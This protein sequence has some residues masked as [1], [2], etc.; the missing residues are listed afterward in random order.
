[1]NGTSRGRSVTLTA[2]GQSG[3]GAVIDVDY[4]GLRHEEITW[5]HVSGKNTVYRAATFS[6][7]LNKKNTDRKRIADF[8][9]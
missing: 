2:W 4:L 6:I 3:G 5:I 9:K 8:G 1:M 7:W